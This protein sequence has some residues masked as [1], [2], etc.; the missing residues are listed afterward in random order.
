M[1][2][3]PKRLARRQRGGG[4]GEQ[5]QFARGQF[6]RGVAGERSQ[7]ARVGAV[8]RSRF[9]RCQGARFTGYSQAPAQNLRGKLRGWRG[10]GESVL[11]G[12]DYAKR[13]GGAEV[14]PPGSRS[15]VVRAEAAGRPGSGRGCRRACDTGKR[16]GATV[17]GWRR[18]IVTSDDDLKPNWSLSCIWSQQTKELEDESP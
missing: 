9:A 2:N 12:C 7:F 15:G 8:E 14:A 1:L 4:T 16:P 11:Q 10:W 13:H 18:T 6:A 17:A 3:K 5:S